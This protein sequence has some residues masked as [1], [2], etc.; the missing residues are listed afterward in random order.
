MPSLKDVGAVG[1]LA[2]LLLASCKTEG[3]EQF[4][5]AAQLKDPTA[6]AQCHED[7]YREWSGSM[8][9]YASRDPIFLAMNAR[10][11]RETNGEIGSFCVQCHAPMALREGAT[12]DGLNLP[13]LPDSLQ[14][15]TCYFCHTAEAVEGSHNNPIV[16]Q[17]EKSGFVD[18][19]E[20]MYGSA[21]DAVPNTVHRSGYS[22]YL[23]G[24]QPESAEMCG[25]CHD[26]VTPNGAH[27]E[28]TFAEWKESL[29]SSDRVQDRLTCGGCHTRG[30]DDYAAKGPQ[31]PDDVPLRRVHDHGMPGVDIAITDFP[32]REAQRAAVQAF[33]DTTLLPRLCVV[34][35]DG[36]STI[37]V[38]L[39]NISAG[40]SFPSG[41]TPDRRAWVE[42]Q[43][44][45]GDQLVLST[46]VL[47]NAEQ[48][49]NELDDPNLWQLGDKIF[50]ADGNEVHMFWEAVSYES[51]LLKA[52]ATSS[53]FGHFSR[54]T[55]VTREYPTTGSLVDR[56]TLKVHIRPM[57]LDII[58]D[59]IASGD[60][61]ASYRSLLPTFTLA[62]SDIEWTR[63]AGECFPY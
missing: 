27:V 45:S 38:T 42:M 58:D 56:V 10:A 17:N 35:V 2:L 8:H 30:R 47:E 53:P 6:C 25:S 36:T 1:L 44:W 16:L 5:T 49:I 11:Q 32:E 20:I 24:E 13:D 63:D 19:E 23:D 37:S 4:I 57:G 22:K 51:E 14:G 3:P 9:A 33:L 59:L 31:A 52:P 55:H 34:D 54:D 39:E 61:D 26:I 12:T 48:A 18:G 60:L 43:A 29:F 40:H 21:V 46:G 41:A 50:D 62:A 28:R 15:V 7:H